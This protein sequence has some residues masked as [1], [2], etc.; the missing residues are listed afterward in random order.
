[1]TTIFCYL[2][3]FSWGLLE[4][5]NA[6]VIE[7]IPPALNTDL[8][9]KAIHDMWES[10][11]SEEDRYCVLVKWSDF[12]SDPETYIDRAFNKRNQPISDKIKVRP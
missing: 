2:Y 11:D 9:G 8:G 6:E 4:N 10:V 3:S 5:N 7:V 12:C 1:M